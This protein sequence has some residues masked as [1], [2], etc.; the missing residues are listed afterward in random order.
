[1]LPHRHPDPPLPLFFVGN[2]NYFG[3]GE[4][5]SEYPYLLPHIWGRTRVAL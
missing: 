5:Q 4:Q 1:M 2:W 3:W